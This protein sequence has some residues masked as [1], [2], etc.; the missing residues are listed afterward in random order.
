MCSQSLSRAQLFATSWTIARQAPLWVAIFP[1]GDLPDPGVKPVSPA[2]QVSFTTEP[3]GKWP[4]LESRFFLPKPALLIIFHC[5]WPL[6]SLSGSDQNTFMSH[7][8]QRIH[9]QIYTYLPL[10]TPS[11]ATSSIQS[12]LAWIIIIASKAISLP[13]YLPSCSSQKN[14]FEINI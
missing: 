11:A 5:D 2:L 4:K 9:Q 13:K 8:P 10:L 3:S 7:S 1:S 14:P 12:S 6:H